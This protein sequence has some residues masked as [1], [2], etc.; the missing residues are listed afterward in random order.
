VVVGSI[1]TL[2]AF[3]PHFGLGWPVFDPLF[4]SERPALSMTSVI[5]FAPST[6]TELIVLVLCPHNK[7]SN[8]KHTTM[9]QH[10][11]TLACV[12]P[13]ALGFAPSFAGRSDLVLHAKRGKGLSVPS[14]TGEAR[15]IGRDAGA[16]AGE[17]VVCKFLVFKVLIAV[18]CVLLLTLV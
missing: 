9:K 17:N 12:L 3:C 13:A 1:P 6:N 11:L 18:A 7:L 5:L 15:G 2:G 10:L 8:T 4:G 14:S 16:G